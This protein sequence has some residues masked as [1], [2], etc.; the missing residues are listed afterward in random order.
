M[1][2]QV[3][4]YTHVDK[5]IQFHYAGSSYCGSFICQFGECV[6]PVLMR[7]RVDCSI[8]SVFG[9]SRVEFVESLAGVICMKH[10]VNR[11]TSHSQMS[12]NPFSAS[13]TIVMP[14]NQESESVKKCSWVK[15]ECSFEQIDRN[16][17]S[18]FTRIEGR[19]TISTRCWL[20]SPK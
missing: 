11:Q 2:I 17:H 14:P 16:Y 3:T 19:V 4:V 5:I 13:E 10:A 20:N 8:S 18:L 12:H 1:D 6:V 15:E 9:S 7:N